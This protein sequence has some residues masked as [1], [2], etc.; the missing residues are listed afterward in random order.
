M[1][2]VAMATTQATMNGDRGFA[3]HSEV[4]KPP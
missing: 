2:P 3:F 1:S 4:G